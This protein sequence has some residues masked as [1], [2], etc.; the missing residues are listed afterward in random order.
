[1][2]STTRPR[3][4]SE[5]LVTRMVGEELLVYDLDR[6]KAY[7]LNPVATQVFRYSD[8][9]T[10]IAEMI[11][12]IRSA[13]GLPIDDQAI[14]LGLM[15]LEAAHLLLDGSVD[16]TL[17]TSRR[18]VLRTLGKTAAVVVPV[19]TALTV[20]TPAQAASFFLC[21]SCPPGCAGQ[22]CAPGFICK[23]RGPLGLHCDPA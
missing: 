22:P 3:A 1:M 2:N 23:P 18:E 9:Q 11:P 20:P 15:R 12:R 10:T 6:H 7:C 8:G 5:R 4:R 19:V 16:P 14:Q 13:V 17:R 21:A